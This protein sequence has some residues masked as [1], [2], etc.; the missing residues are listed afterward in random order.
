MNNEKDKKEEY[1]PR[2]LLE[3]K[4]N[5][6]PAL[7]KKLGYK[8][9]H[10]IPKLEK[11]VINV[12]FGEAISNPKLLETVMNDIAIITGQWPVKRRARRSVS[13]FKLR[14]GVPIGCKV[15]IR[16][17]RMYEFYDRLVNTA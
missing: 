1:Q 16:G 7:K 10:E 17:K 11:I 2:L 4:N 6:V 3:Y 8:N 12:G 14:A 5:V 13:N 15:T 9:I